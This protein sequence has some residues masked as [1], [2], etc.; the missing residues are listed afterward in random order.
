MA[1]GPEKLDVDRAAIASVGWACRY[2]EK[3]KGHR[4][5]TD[6]LPRASQ[7]IALKTIED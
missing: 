7:T 4:N 6:Q 3:R 2:C 1:F 5:A